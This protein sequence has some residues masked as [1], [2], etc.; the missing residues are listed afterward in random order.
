MRNI[1]KTYYRR[2]GSNID[3]FNYGSKIDAMADREGVYYMDIGETGAI[4]NN[5]CIGRV[6]YAKRYRDIVEYQKK[7]YHAIRN[8]SYACVLDGMAN[9]YPVTCIWHKEKIN[10][11]LVFFIEGNGFYCHEMAPD[12]V[13]EALSSMA[14]IL[15]RFPV[16]MEEKIDRLSDFLGNHYI[17][18]GLPEETWPKT[19]N[20]VMEKY[21]TIEDEATQRVIKRLAYEDNLEKMFFSNGLTSPKATKVLSDLLV[22]PEKSPEEIDRIMIDLVI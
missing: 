3:D 13:K 10:L 4:F 6:V 8:E 22:Q 18:G 1:G 12:E 14:R 16:R 21:R 5:P 7:M 2:S 9:M 19:F 11:P 20:Q 15:P 17:F